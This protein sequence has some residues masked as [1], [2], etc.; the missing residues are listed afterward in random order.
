[1]NVQVNE[2]LRRV[3]RSD[4]GLYWRGHS[5]AIGYIAEAHFLLVR[6]RELSSELMSTLLAGISV[7]EDNLRSLRHDV[8]HAVALEFNGYIRACLAIAHSSGKPF[9]MDNM[10]VLTRLYKFC[11]AIDCYTD[12]SLYHSLQH[13]IAFANCL[14]ALLKGQWPTPDEPV[15]IVY[16]LALEQ[17]TEEGQV[18][19]LHSEVFDLRRREHEFMQ[20]LN[21]ATKHQKGLQTLV[22]VL[23]SITIMMPLAFYFFSIY[24][25]DAQSFWSALGVVVAITSVMAGAAVTFIWQRPVK[26]RLD[27]IKKGRN[28]DLE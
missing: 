16:Q 22:V 14:I 7:S 2:L 10:V 19:Q 26:Y 3:Q 18:A 25:Q 8:G 6:E 5:E 20:L 11:R 15:M 9:S 4:S 23:A 1:M 17:A 12:G 13:T 27:S 21:Q 24:K 28:D